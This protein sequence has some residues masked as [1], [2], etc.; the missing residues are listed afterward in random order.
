MQ[1]STY[2]QR[3]Q[4]MYNSAMQ[5][6]KPPQ[7]D[8]EAIAD[9]MLSTMDSDSDGSI[10]SEEFSDTVMA[11][12]ELSSEEVET[13]FKQLDS[14]AS[15]TMS[16]QELVSA[17]ETMAKESGPAGVGAMPPPPPP[18]PPSDAAQSSDEEE[19][20]EELFATL[21]SDNDDSISQSELMS[22]LDTDA[23]QTISQEELETF[24]ST[25]TTQT[26]SS[27]EEAQET[28]TQ[29]SQE[30]TALYDEMI[31]RLISNYVKS[32]EESLS[33]SSLNLSA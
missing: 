21:D 10:S 2:D 32:Y 4:Q 22:A 30:E 19:S 27:I 15:G 12:S 14:D 1:V 17:L 6:Q 13:F 3:Y 18:P 11:N 25:A 29:E 23:S 33:S 9:E 8:F 7:Q 28:S 31:Q 16:S 26:Q 5:P 24:V 20:I